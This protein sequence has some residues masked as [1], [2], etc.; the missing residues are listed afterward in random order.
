MKICKKCESKHTD[1]N[2]FCPKCKSILFPYQ[3]TKEIQNSNP[4]V[5]TKSRTKKDSSIHIQVKSPEVDKITNYGLWDPPAP[6]NI[7]DKIYNISDEDLKYGISMGLHSY[8]LKRI[9]INVDKRIYCCENCS[10]FL[11][12]DN[13]CN[14]KNFKIYPLTS[15][16]KSYEPKPEF[17]LSTIKKEKIVKTVINSGTVN[18]GKKKTKSRR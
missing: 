18:D 17:G 12:I 6:R 8:K 1:S 15:I 3:E 16:C 10:Y 14:K 7:L 11:D 5:Q 13:T 9:K 4:K 2:H